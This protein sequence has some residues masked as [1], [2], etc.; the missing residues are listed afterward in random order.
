MDHERNSENKAKIIIK[1]THAQMRT[2]RDELKVNG[3]KATR[4]NEKEK[5]M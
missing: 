2:K 3:R 4:E 1:K 5:V